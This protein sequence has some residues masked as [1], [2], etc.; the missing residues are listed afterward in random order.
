MIAIRSF[1]E[2]VT[3]ELGNKTKL[4]G[5]LYSSIKLI[6]KSCKDDCSVC[7]L[8]ELADT[9]DERLKW[10]STD[11][12]AAIFEWCFSR[13]GS[14]YPLCTNMTGQANRC[15]MYRAK[16][17][18]LLAKGDKTLPLHSRPAIAG[19]SICLD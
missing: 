3:V 12:A 8:K 14:G 7:S 6:C 9:A 11:M 16:Q 4:V 13:C 17:L 1:N 15:I 19:E 10:Y 2:E 5:A 18:A